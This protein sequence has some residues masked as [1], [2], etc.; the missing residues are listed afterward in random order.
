MLIRIKILELGLEGYDGPL[1]SQRCIESLSA[2]A[3]K[4]W[5]SREKKSDII[6]ESQK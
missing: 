2:A 1:K 5:E 3:N 4:A 6:K